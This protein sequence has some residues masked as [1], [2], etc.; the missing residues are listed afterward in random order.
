VRRRCPEGYILGTNFRGVKFT[1]G[2]STDAKII[3]SCTDTTGVINQE[4]KEGILIQTTVS[5]YPFV[6]FTTAQ[7]AAGNFY[8]TTSYRGIFDG[9]CYAIEY[10]IHSTNIGNYSPDQGIKEFDKTKIVTEMENI[11]KSFKFLISSN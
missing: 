3:K 7:G 10:T 9:D 11:I 6:K 2:R 5:G 1:I 4:N 8:E